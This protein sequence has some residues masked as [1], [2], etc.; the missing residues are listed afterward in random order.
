MFNFNRKFRAF[1]QDL[2]LSLVEHQVGIDPS[3]KLTL[4]ASAFDPKAVEVLRDS[5]GIDV[6][7]D[8]NAGNQMSEIQKILDRPMLFGIFA[9]KMWR[10][11]ESQSIKDMKFDGTLLEKFVELWP[12]IFAIIVD[13]TTL[14]AKF[15]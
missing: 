3:D 7:L 11:Q 15:V 8:F 6:T 4:N 10:A 13:I 2:R 9:R 1:K 14:F 12:K 5:E